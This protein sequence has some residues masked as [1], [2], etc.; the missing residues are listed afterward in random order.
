MK[1]SI[2]LSLLSCALFAGKIN[3]GVLSKYY[4]TGNDGYAYVVQG[5]SVINSFQMVNSDPGPILIVGSNL[6]VTANSG[7]DFGG[8]YDIDG[9]PTGE[10]FTNPSRGIPIER[11]GATDGTHLYGLSILAQDIMIYDRSFS[12]R[13]TLKHWSTQLGLRYRGI[14][15]DPT[16]NTFW[17]SGNTIAEMHH[18]DIAGNFISSFPIATSSAS[19]LALD[20]VDGTLWFNKN[21]TNDLYQYSKSGQLLDSFTVQNLPTQ[22]YSGGDIYIVPEPASA[23]LLM[24]LLGLLSRRSQRMARGGA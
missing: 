22:Q 12:N 4:L 2:Y 23:A 3:A 15:Y 11:D 13:Q 7:T 21:G 17:L 6:I 10:T 1:F 14:A 19:A 20:P 24:S 16:D 18:V 9:N 5:Q 8:Y